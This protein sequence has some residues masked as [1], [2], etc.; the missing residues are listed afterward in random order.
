MAAASVARP[1]PCR[2]CSGAVA[3]L[4]MPTTSPVPVVMAVLTGRPSRRARKTASLSA[5]RTQGPKARTTEASGRPKASAS[6]RWTTAKSSGVVTRSARHRPASPQPAT[7]PRDRC[8]IRGRSPTGC[9]PRS[10]GT[11]A[12][13]TRAGSRRPAKAAAKVCSRSSAAGPALTWARLRSATGS[14]LSASQPSAVNCPSPPG[15]PP[16]GARRPRRRGATATTG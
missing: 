7:G 16:Y 6:S 3:M 8:T 9:K 13:R 11:G 15:S 4:Q 12:R 5:S 2:R 1:A 14:P 10:R